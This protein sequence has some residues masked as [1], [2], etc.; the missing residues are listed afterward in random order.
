MKMNNSEHNNEVTSR[1][2][3]FLRGESDEKPENIL[4]D[5]FTGHLTDNL[6]FQ[7]G[8][9]Y[10]SREDMIIRGW[11]RVG[12]Y[13]NMK[14]ELGEYFFTDDQLIVHGFYVG[15]AIKTGKPVRAAFAH[16]WTVKDQK[17]TR[18]YQVTDSAAWLLA[19]QIE[20]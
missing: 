19:S 12:Q 16:F 6:P 9:D 3:S 10:T 1:L 2:Y 20:N 4:A 17:F 15:V 13:F 8:G 11:G 18:V 14:P 7:L 5:N